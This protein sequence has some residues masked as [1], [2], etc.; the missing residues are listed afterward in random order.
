MGGFQVSFPA[1]GRLPMPGA[2]RRW[3]PRKLAR[4]Q[5]Q[6][7]AIVPKAI[8][9]SGELPMTHRDPF[10]RRLAAQAIDAGRTVLSPDAPLS[11][12]EAWRLW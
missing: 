8:F 2:P 11:A 4:H 5:L 9:L 10:D 6:L 7:L 3:L 12:L 1:A